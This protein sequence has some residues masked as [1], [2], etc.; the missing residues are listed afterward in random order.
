MLDFAFIDSAVQK[1]ANNKPRAVAVGHNQY[2]APV[3]DL[4]YHIAPLFVVENAKAV[5]LDYRRVY[6]VFEL[7]FVVPAL[8]YHGFL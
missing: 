6:Q 7:D 4:A 2:P 8:D 1:I 5:C 3:G